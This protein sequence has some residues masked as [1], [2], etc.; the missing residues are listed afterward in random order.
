[1]EEKQIGEEAD[2]FVQQ[3]GD[4]ARQHTDHGGE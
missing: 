4:A 3:I 1:M 2:Q